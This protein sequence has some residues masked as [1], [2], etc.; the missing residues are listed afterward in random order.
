M[1]IPDAFAMAPPNQR[2]FALVPTTLVSTTSSKPPMT[3]RAAKKAYSKS[4]QA[5]RVSRA[6][7]RRRDAEDLDKIKKDAE[8]E[9]RTKAARAAR[10]KKAEKEEL[11]R[12]E[13][14]RRGEAEK[15]RWVRASQPSIKGFAFGGI[16]KRKRDD[17]EESE[18]T[19]SGDEEEGRRKRI[20]VVT[21]EDESIEETDTKKADTEVSRRIQVAAAHSMRPPVTNKVA[22]QLEDKPESEDEFGDFPALSQP[23]LL[24]AILSSSIRSTPPV[25]RVR[26][27]K[28]L[29]EA[30]VDGAMEEASQELPVH[31]KRHDDDVLF[32]NT[33]DEA[34]L[35]RA[36]IRSEEA[37][38][39]ARSDPVEDPPKNR[40]IAMQQ[41]GQMQK[42]G[43]P[44]PVLKLD[45]RSE[46]DLIRE[47]NR[48]DVAPPPRVQ[49]AVVFKV[50]ALPA[51]RKDVPPSRPHPTTAIANCA[52]PSTQAFL[53][54]N[55]DDFMLTPSQEARELLAE[56]EDEDLPTSN[57]HL[58]RGQA[59]INL[60]SPKRSAVDDLIDDF[61]CTQDL[62]LSSQDMV[63]ISPTKPPLPKVPRSFPN[64]T[65]S[66]PPPA[67]KKPP[68]PKVPGSHPS[69]T[70]PM[71]PPAYKKPPGSNARL[72]APTSVT[73]IASPK[74]GTL[75]PVPND[76][77]VH[78][79]PVMDD[80]PS[81]QDFILSPDD[82]KELNTPSKETLAIEKTSQ[83]LAA[84]LRK[85]LAPAFQ[86]RD[87][88]FHMASDP[89][90]APVH[91]LPQ[92]PRQDAP[93][94]KS[95]SN[96]PPV[97]NNTSTHSAN[98]APVR[99]SGRQALSETGLNTIVP[100]TTKPQTR[101]STP[102][103]NIAAPPRKTP[104]N[105]SPQP[106]ISR[107]RSRG[108][109]KPRFFEE[110]ENDLFQAAI[111]ES[112]LLAEKAIT[113][114]VPSAKVSSHTNS[115]RPHVGR[116]NAPRA[117]AA[118]AARGNVSPA[119]TGLME[120]EEKGGSRSGAS[121]KRKLKRV[122]SLV[123]D[124]GDDEF[125]GICEEDLVGVLG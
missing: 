52:P 67:F 59:A 121:A 89:V 32:G 73:T 42:Q 69:R 123:S 122:E 118:V 100:T 54:D 85:L 21:E 50:P 24:E 101:T 105:P 65:T 120:S 55:I 106:Q 97:K 36:Q 76:N 47:T 7:Q 84:Q 56:D 112:K 70:T 57:N 83:N 10:E 87:Y 102:N 103:S 119:K 66:M 98:H 38:A 99:Q 14:K 22:E 117:A 80:F 72:N 115:S 81:T 1:A 4:N 13:R 108:S 93:S 45:E 96:I 25:Q 71:A 6:E 109:T 30:H 53:E 8:K 5:P 40:N 82:L 20:A 111:H 78:N 3:S 75:L 64:K 33:Q 92:P 61:I 94:R 107:P 74:V 60:P 51:P 49:D 68:V 63:E 2:I 17:G 39:V 125:E 12:R 41:R 27:P 46:N 91:H 37:E 35:L 110:K 28:V 43:A 19:A 95:T 34:D 88:T 29:L 23:A 26:Q 9:K 48:V 90:H 11:E 18:G 104:S 113:P 124:Y 58:S 16:G 15:S 44:E 77:D 114:S 31:R 62:I 116:R 86:E 79:D